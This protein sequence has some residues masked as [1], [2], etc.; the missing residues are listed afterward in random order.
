[1]LTRTRSR[2]TQLAT[3][4]VLAAL[5]LTNV[6]FAQEMSKKQKKKILSGARS[7]SKAFNLAAEEA[8]PSVVKILS[9]T[10]KEGENEDRILSI[11]G[12]DDVQV[13]DS[14]GSGVIV[15]PDGLIITNAHVIENSTRLEVRLSDGR[16]FES[17][18]TKADPRSDIAIIRIKA[19]TTLP[20]ATLGSSEALDIGEWVLAIGSPFMLESS[21]SAGILSGRRSDQRLS[22]K[23]RGQVLQTDA[24]INPGNSGGPLINLD[25]DVVGINTAISSRTGGSQGIGFAIPIERA[26][27]IRRELLKYDRVRRGYVGV[28]TAPVPYEMVKE[29]G[30]PGGGGAQV[31]DV[32]PDYPADKAG[33]ESGDVIIEFNGFAVDSAAKFAGLVQQAEIGKPFKLLVV[34]DGK[35]L[36]LSIELVERR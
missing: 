29:L 12:G 11:I 8:L 10:K 4:L 16:R 32:V 13:F 33:L 27:W 6:A 24:A 14:V 20:V 35:Q 22:Q 28:R 7:L 25:G 15:S 17:V 26:D 9:R 2:I 30:L 23:V 36:E 21:V 18:E 34:R 5:C 19:D 3:T 1:M 31:G